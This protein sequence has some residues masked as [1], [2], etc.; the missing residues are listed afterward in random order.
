M[1]V[2]IAGKLVLTVIIVWFLLAH[3][4]IDRLV[5]NL[6]RI[7]GKWFLWAF[8]CWPVVVLVSG[9]KWYE[10]IRAEAPGLT[11]REA[12]R[13]FLGGTF[14]GLLTPGRLGEF[15]KVALIRQGHLPLLTRDRIAGT[16]AGCGSFDDHGIGGVW[17][18]FGPKSFVVVLDDC[19]CVGHCFI[20]QQ[21]AQ[22][23]SC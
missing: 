22:T 12:I 19:V 7:D 8:L 10:I 17:V 20:G 1:N 15:G 6:S 9:L 16:N 21:S 11:Y 3:I 5:T 14:F 2:K 23:T 4:G 18:L 13:A